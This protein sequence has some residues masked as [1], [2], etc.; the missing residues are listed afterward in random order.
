[1]DEVTE[2]CRLMEVRK[3]LARSD[4]VGEVE[5][6]F[7]FLEG[8]DKAK[9]GPIL[10]E[11]VRV[12]GFE[13]ENCF[14]VAYIVSYHRGFGYAKMALRRLKASMAICSHSTSNV[15]PI[16]S[17]KGSALWACSMVTTSPRQKRWLPD[18]HR[19]TS[20]KATPQSQTLSVLPALGKKIRPSLG[21]PQGGC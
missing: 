15:K 9:G 7:S 19:S 10:G 5:L 16:C 17:M 1:M 11:A 4:E 20:R 8:W 14:E 6:L 2:R 18:R 3:S 21:R 13:R 12:L